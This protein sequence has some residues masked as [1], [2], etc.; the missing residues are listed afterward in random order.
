MEGARIQIEDFSAD[1]FMF[2]KSELVDEITQ[3]VMKQLGSNIADNSALLSKEGGNESVKFN[4]LLEKYSKS[5]EDIDF[6]YEGLSDEDLEDAFAKRFDG[7]NPETPSEDQTAADAVAALINALPSTITAD[8]EDEITAARTAYDALTDEQ[9]ALI[10]S[11]VLA[12]LTS[13]E[14]SLGE[15][16]AAAANQ[17]AADTVTAAINALPSDATLDD[18]DAVSNARQAYNSLTPAQK[19]LV[20][21]E[22]VAALEAAE[23]SVNIARANSEDVGNVKRKRNDNELVYSVT[24]NGETKSFAVSLIDKLNALSELVNN[25]YS[26][27]DDAFYD[28][29]AYEED[30]YVIMH[31]Y[32]HNKHYRQ[33]YGVKK[34]VYS[35]K[36]DRVEVFAQWLTSDE[37][38]KL[39]S[40]KSKY[41]ETID[42]LANYEAEPEKMAILNSSDYEQIANSDEFIELKNI[43]VH[44]N[45]TVDEV[46][47]KADELLLSFAKGNKID[48]SNN[49]GN[50]SISVKKFV[51]K[52]PNKTGRYGKLFKK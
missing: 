31:D 47:S 7:E 50:T 12:I 36:G 25:T 9:K 33:S 3:A 1:N 6:E 34:D 42:R 39:D 52:T 26:E 38:T 46:R 28:I 40:M 24:I 10:N 49:K 17:T 20:S 13:A 23:E 11:D 21:S 27:A 29:D 14:V 30:K 2:S 32:W 4:E 51:S 37:I 43:D 44:F 35:L 45:M 19:E 22:V 18:A 41:S 15:I 16:Q 5:L 8:E 48:F